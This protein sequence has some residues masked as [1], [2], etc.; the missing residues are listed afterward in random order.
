[1][2]KKAMHVTCA[3][4]C[5]CRLTCELIT[6]YLYR[7]KDCSWQYDLSTGRA[8]NRRLHC[9]S[10]ICTATVRLS[11]EVLSLTCRCYCSVIYV[12][13]PHALSWYTAISTANMTSAAIIIGYGPK[14][15][16][17][18]SETLG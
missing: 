18:I 7:W 17:A 4:R 12:F 14:I 13:D 6:G 9:N 5:S 1:M 3:L 2:R 11:Y 8:S 16:L 15:G 10:A